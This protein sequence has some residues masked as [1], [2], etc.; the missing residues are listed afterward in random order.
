MT[1]TLAHSN[2]RIKF[3]ELL[4]LKFCIKLSN[5]TDC[6]RQSRVFL[7]NCL[8]D[9][10]VVHSKVV[11]PNTL[12]KFKFIAAFHYDYSSQNEIKIMNLIQIKENYYNQMLP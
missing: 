7:N 11:L 9:F 5:F 4:L 2:N 10:I 12:R 1:S 3:Q 6:C 8:E